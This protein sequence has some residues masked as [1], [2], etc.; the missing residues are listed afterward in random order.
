M[1][2]TRHLITQRIF[3]ISQN[4]YFTLVLH[5]W[6]RKTE[7]L[8]NISYILHSV[9]FISIE[10]GKN[11][12]YH[13]MRWRTVTQSHKILCSPLEGRLDPWLT[14][15]RPAETLCNL[16]FRW[17]HKSWDTFLTLTHML[18]NPFTSSGLLY[19][20]SLDRSIFNSR[21]SCQ[22]FFFAYRNSCI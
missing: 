2:R 20:I 9:H 16:T 21:V 19:H 15:E 13:T 8:V 7:C 12:L 1:Q 14:K 5:I 3:I 18:F 22:L 6:K 10:S 11:D 17:E 4:K